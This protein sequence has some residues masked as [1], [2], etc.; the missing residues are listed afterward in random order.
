MDFYAY[1]LGTED[2]RAPVDLYRALRRVR[3]AADIR[4]G[5]EIASANELQGFGE[6]RDLA[7]GVP[8]ETVGLLEVHRKTMGTPLWDKGRIVLP[9]DDVIPHDVY[10]VPTTTG[11]MMVVLGG[12]A[13]GTP[14]TGGR[15]RR[16]SER[17]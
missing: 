9:G 8:P 15:R 16:G 12:W 4:A 5:H 7:R 3:D 6:S 1:S 11:F 17:D 14:R 10:A 2:A 13:R